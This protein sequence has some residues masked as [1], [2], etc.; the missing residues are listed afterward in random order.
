MNNR[1]NRRWKVSGRVALMLALAVSCTEAFAATIAYWPLAYTAGGRTTTETELTN[2]VQSTTL[3]AR[4]I[5]MLGGD[6]QSGNA[7]CPVGTN[8]FPVGF[9]VYDPVAAE[10][11]DAETAL[12]FELP[13]N[14]ETQGSGA[15]RV[16]NTA[17]L[18]IS[19]F[20]VEFFI[21]IRQPYT[22][23]QMGQYH[24]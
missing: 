9:A 17:P 6:V 18:R 13:A 12:H 8:A 3:V 20:T 16:S 23:T 4:P 2:Y 5:S 15:V 7:S 10:T 22:Q 21:R 1:G 11:R 24:A 14:R 19:T